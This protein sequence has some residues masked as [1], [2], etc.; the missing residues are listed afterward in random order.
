[1]WVD[2]SLLQH[3]GQVVRTLD[4]GADDLDSI[5]GVGAIKGNF[6]FLAAFQCFR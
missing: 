6:N 1:M 5:S 3:V 2:F 4:C